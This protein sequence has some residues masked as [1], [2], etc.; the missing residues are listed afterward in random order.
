MLAAMSANNAAALILFLHA[1]DAANLCDR[2]QAPVMR[3]SSGHAIP[4]C[5]TSFARSSHLCTAGNF[6]LPTLADP[7]ALYAWPYAVHAG[8]HTI[9][10]GPHT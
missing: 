5:V 10:T 7:Q 2:D 8:S 6:S 4:A 3:L 9:H 1:N